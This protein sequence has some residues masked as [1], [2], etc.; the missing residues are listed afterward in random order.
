MMAESLVKK[1][2]SIL[3]Y[4]LLGKGERN[5]AYIMYFLCVEF[6]RILLNFIEP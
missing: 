4:L 1:N 2:C 5:M 3:I 6:S